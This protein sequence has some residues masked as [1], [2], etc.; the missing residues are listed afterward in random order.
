MWGDVFLRRTKFEKCLSIMLKMSIIHEKRFCVHRWRTIRRF[1]FSIV[2]KMSIVHE[3]SKEKSQTT[4]L[5]YN[6]L[7]YNLAF[8][9]CG[10]STFSTL[11]ECFLSS[12]LH[13]TLTICPLIACTISIL[14]TIG[15]WASGIWLLTSHFSLLS[16]D[17]ADWQTGVDVI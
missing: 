15:T 17:V 7:K 5:R 8:I 11:S 1:C 3:T 4:L 6:V 16:S 2:L 9:L 13:L 12:F 14:S 10:L